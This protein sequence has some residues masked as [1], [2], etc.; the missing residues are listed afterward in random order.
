MK[1]PIESQQSKNH[2]LKLYVLTQG[3]RSYH[4]VL[5][6]WVVGVLG[7]VWSTALPLR[8]D[9]MTAISMEPVKKPHMSKEIMNLCTY[10]EPAAFL[11]K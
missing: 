2:A 10:R 6:S 5:Y 7:V 4:K 1:E 8:V 3:R 9:L 11:K